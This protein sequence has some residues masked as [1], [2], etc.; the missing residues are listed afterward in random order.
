MEKKSVNEQPISKETAQL[1]IEKGCDLVD[2]KKKYSTFS[3]WGDATFFCENFVG[4]LNDTSYKISDGGRDEHGG[5]YTCSITLSEFNNLPT[6]S[7]LQRWLREIH[8]IEIA[9]QW[10]DTC[11]I[12]S[13][14]QKPFKANTYRVEGF[15]NY[16]EI[17]EL[18][19]VEGLNKIN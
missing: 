7:L 16:E 6:Q 14:K 17:L 19:L 5:N 10:F 8:N 18:A 13:V 1:A 9:V 15:S 12:K 3:R 11:Y 2:F 4:K